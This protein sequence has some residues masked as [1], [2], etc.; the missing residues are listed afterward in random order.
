MRSGKRFVGRSGCHEVAGRDLILLRRV[1]ERAGEPNHLS[2]VRTRPRHEQR[3]LG[4]V[5]DELERTNK[6]T[7]LVT[8][9]IGGGMGTATIIERV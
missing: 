3:I 1:T 8:L 9:C 5:L 2:V 7:A 4:T 6:N